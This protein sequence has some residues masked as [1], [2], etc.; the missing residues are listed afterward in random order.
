MTYEKKSKTI[1]VK[2]CKASG[3]ANQ[4]NGEYHICLPEYQT[5]E[6]KIPLVT[7]PL[8]I[9]V[10]LTNPAPVK[11]C[12]FKDIVLTE[13]VCEDVIEQRC[14]NVAE[15][16]DSVNIVD[17]QEI[18][19][20]EPNCNSVTLEL[21]TKTCNIPYKSWNQSYHLMLLLKSCYIK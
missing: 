15:L 11:T 4:Y 3:Y 6:Y 12:V 10:N 21:P 2:N 19:I 14:F 1:K 18:I 5:Q 16:V 7:A 20:D 17:Q 13:V 9:A 8:D